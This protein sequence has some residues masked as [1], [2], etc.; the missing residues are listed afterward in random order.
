MRK[1][2]SS[3]PKT[4]QLSGTLE[5]LTRFLPTAENGDAEKHRAVSCYSLKVL[6]QSRSDLL[7][8]IAE[9]RFATIT[10]NNAGSNASSDVCY[11]NTNTVHLF[12][13]FF[14]SCY[15]FAFLARLY[16]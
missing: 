16:K 6:G 8:R 2:Q 3:N 12:I 7:H 10:R 13:F 11:H 15:F 9:E 14:S 4:V 1:L 5:C